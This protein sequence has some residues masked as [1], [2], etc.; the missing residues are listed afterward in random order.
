MSETGLGSLNLDQLSWSWLA[1]LT[2]LVEVLLEAPQLGLIHENLLAT[3]GLNQNMLAT[4]LLF[5]RLG[6]ALHLD[7]LLPAVLR[8]EDQLL[9][10]SHAW[11]ASFL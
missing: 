11:A 8:L 3:A 7:N 4:G 10:W 9:G 5:T 1:L 6:P 2:V